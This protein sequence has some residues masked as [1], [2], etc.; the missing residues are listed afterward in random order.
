MFRDQVKTFQADFKSWLFV[1]ACSTLC[2]YLRS[3]FDCRYTLTCPSKLKGLVCIARK[4]GG[5]LLLLKFLCIYKKLDGWES[6]T[7]EPGPFRV[8]VKL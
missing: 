2:K 8:P 5:S 3:S 7:K 4:T 6:G 1:N